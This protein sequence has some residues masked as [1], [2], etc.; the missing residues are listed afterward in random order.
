MQAHEIEQ[1]LSQLEQEL[2]NLGVQRPL[3][4]LLIGGAYMMLLA[5]ASRRA[6]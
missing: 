6:A 2:G 4:V 1:Y 5:H 3:R